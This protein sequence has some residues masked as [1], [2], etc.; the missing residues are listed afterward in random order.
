MNVQIL[1]QP[2][3][4]GDYREERFEAAGAC[5][6]VMFQ[7]SD[8]E[9]WVGVS[10]RGRYFPNAVAWHESGEA[11]IV[12]GGR[13]YLID[14][15]KRTLLHRT[16]KEYFVDVVAGPIPGAFIVADE[17]YLYAYDASGQRWRTHRISW[18]GIRNLTLEGHLLRG[19]SWGLDDWY[20]F[21]LDLC[22]G[23]VAGATYNGPGAR[24]E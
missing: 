9:D 20:R 19:E 4:S 11:F 10:G 16:E 3:P 6:W 24:Y 12:A 23:E 14:T 17:L 2:T 18:D 21:T 8:E 22:T 15:R 7:L 1:G 13:G 5:T